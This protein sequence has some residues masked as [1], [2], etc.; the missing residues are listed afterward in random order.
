[1]SGH[2]QALPSSQKQLRAQTDPG[3][4]DFVSIGI[5][6]RKQK[7]ISGTVHFFV[8][9]VCC[10]G[11]WVPIKM[12]IRKANAKENL[13]DVVCLPITKAKT[14][15]NPQIF[16]CN[17]IGMAGTTWGNI[18][19]RKGLFWSEVVFKIFISCFSWFRGSSKC[20]L[21]GPNPPV[22]NP[23]VAKR[24][25]WRSSES[26]AAG[27]SSPSGN[28]YSFLSFPLHIWQPRQ[29]PVLTRTDS[30]FSYLG[31]SKGG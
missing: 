20:Y 13:G 28:A 5:R 16:I 4:Y 31:I 25:S 10:S 7:E 14:R 3:I 11:L 24:A 8:S 23:A 29:T 30:D 6:K 12:F 9:V 2:F 27:V 1:M 15:E 18:G 21:W 26:G 19:V 22:S 17:R